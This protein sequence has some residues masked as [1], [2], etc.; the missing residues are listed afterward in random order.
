MNMT[1]SPEINELTVALNKFQSQVGP[2]VKNATN[3]FFKS[4]YATLENVWQTIHKPLCDNGLAVAQFPIENGIATII[5][6]VSGQW[7]RA[8]FVMPSKDNSPQ[9]IGSVITYAR[10]YSLMAVLNVPAE[11]DDAE[12]GQGRS[13]EQKPPKINDTPQQRTQQPETPKQ[14]GAVSER[15]LKRLYAITKNAGYDYNSVDRYIKATFKV[16]SKSDMTRAQYDEVCEGLESN[17]L[18]LQLE[19]PVE[20]GDLVYDEPPPMTDKDVPF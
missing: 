2:V 18:N 20:V 7:M 9:A 4:K 5:S 12:K 13:T 15:Q 8:Y 16:A 3:P 6:H 14:P 10:R 17:T 11:D 19:A 1:M